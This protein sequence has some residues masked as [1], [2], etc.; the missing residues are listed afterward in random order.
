MWQN[1][2]RSRKRQQMSDFSEDLLAIKLPHG[3]AREGEDQQ[4]SKG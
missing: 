3:G 4:L 2:W 1:C